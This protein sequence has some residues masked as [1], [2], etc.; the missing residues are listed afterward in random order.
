MIY[1][2]R[3][4]R[5]PERVLLYHTANRNHIFDKNTTNSACTATYINQIYVCVCSDFKLLSLVT[6][7]ESIIPFPFSSF[8]DSK[9]KRQMMDH[10]EAIGVVAVG[11]LDLVHRRDGQQRI[12]RTQRGTDR[13]R[14]ECVTTNN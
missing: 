4:I 12:P 11:I 10:V 9:N 1:N 6:R 5:S 3:T 14:E 8:S 7:D 13:A 2:A